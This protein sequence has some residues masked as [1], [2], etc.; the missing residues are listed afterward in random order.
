MVEWLNV[1]TQM[2]FLQGGPQYNINT[3]F[4]P[5]TTDYAL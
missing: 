1:I 5:N 3:V 4:S 2:I